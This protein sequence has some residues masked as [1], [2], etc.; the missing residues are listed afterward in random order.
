M[1]E[2]LIIATHEIDE[3]ICSYPSISGS[4]QSMIRNRAPY[5]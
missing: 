4:Q 3:R 1:K 5:G 2:Q